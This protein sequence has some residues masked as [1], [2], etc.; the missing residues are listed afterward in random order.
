MG[1]YII[2]RLLLMIPVIIGVTLLIFLLQAFTPGDPAQLALGSVL[3][4]R[5]WNSGARNEG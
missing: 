3:P 2:K 1:R 5:N 4:R